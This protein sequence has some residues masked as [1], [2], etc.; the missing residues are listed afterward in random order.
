VTGTTSS[1]PSESN[2]ILQQP[3]TDDRPA[4]RL[5]AEALTIID[6]ARRHGAQLRLTGGLAVRRYCT[7][8]DFMEREF[9]DIDFIGLA[10]QNR[11]LQRVFSDLGYEENSYVTQSTGGAQLQFLRR[12]QLREW[13]AGVLESPPRERP[14]TLAAPAVDHV[15][16]FMDVMRMD[17]DVDVRD[18]LHIDDYAISPV[19]ILITKLQIGTISEK[20]VHD[21]IAL[22]KDIPLGEKDDNLSVNLPHLAWVCS[23]DWGIYYDITANLGT[24]LKRLDDYPLS[25]EDSDRVYGRISAIEEAIEDEKK[26]IRWRLRARVGERL[27]WR[28]EVEEREGSPIIA[29]QWDSRRDLG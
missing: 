1:S 7:D 24:V 20:D 4:D 23:R 6:T 17:H 5:M 29:P 15:D 21:V 12:A 22:L 11:R 26:P 19:D 28:R 27:P 13:R 8:L 14:L 18:R 16:I 10:V 25:A 2:Y 3:Q 9:S